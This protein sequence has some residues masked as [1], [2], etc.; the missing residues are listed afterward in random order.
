MNKLQ[1]LHWP[2]R[3]VSINDPV[4]VQSELNT[5]QNAYMPNSYEKRPML[6]VDPFFG[7]AKQK[8]NGIAP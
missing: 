8:A 3:P 5:R 6:W 2:G 1:L 7:E 4:V